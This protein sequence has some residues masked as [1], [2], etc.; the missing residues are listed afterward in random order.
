V[1]CDI[2]EYKKFVFDQ[3][4]GFI[5]EKEDRTCPT[6]ANE[7]KY[8][9]V[10]RPTIELVVTLLTTLYKVELLTYPAVARPLTVLV[11]CDVL[12]NPIDARPV[13]LLFNWEVLI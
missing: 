7:E 6:V 5:F 4:P 3:F 11:N 1:D 8:P 9:I 10:P 12:I 13:I 2:F